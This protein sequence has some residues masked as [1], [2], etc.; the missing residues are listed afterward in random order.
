MYA[1]HGKLPIKWGLFGE[2]K[3]KNRIDTTG[4]YVMNYQMIIIVMVGENSS[5]YNCQGNL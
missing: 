1:T 4:Q 3:K 2:K 5:G